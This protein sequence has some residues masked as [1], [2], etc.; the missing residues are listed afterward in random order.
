MKPS[1][2]AKLALETFR[3]IQGQQTVSEV[4]V[5]A[6]EAPAKRNE[7]WHV[8]IGYSPSREVLGVPVSGM[9]MRSVIR[10]TK[11]GAFLG[12]SRVERNNL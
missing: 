6:I 2:V 7:E 5:E 11:D 9:R 10:L 3:E 12:M 4:L 8:T 1:E